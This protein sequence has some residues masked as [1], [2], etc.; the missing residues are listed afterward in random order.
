MAE[1]AKKA[2]GKQGVRAGSDHGAHSAF[3]KTATPSS[4]KSAA[5][6]KTNYKHR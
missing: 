2:D 6:G 3:Q 5:S 1:G 4:I